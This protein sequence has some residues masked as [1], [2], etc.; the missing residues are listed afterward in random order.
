MLC[1]ESDEQQVNEFT[2]DH[3]RLIKK[4]KE[5]EQQGVNLQR[6]IVESAPK[7]QTETTNSDEYTD[8]FYLTMLQNVSKA[9]QTLTIKTTE[10]QE[11]VNQIK[12][13]YEEKERKADAMENELEDFQIDNAKIY[14]NKENN[15]KFEE[16][17][18]ADEKKR[19]VVE[20]KRLAVIKMKLQTIQMENKIL[21]KEKLVHGL[22]IAGFEQIKAKNKKLDQILNDKKKELDQL[23]KKHSLVI[24]ES[25]ETRNTIN[26]LSEEI[27]KERNI[28]KVSDESIQKKEQLLSHLELQS[29]SYKKSYTISK[30][31]SQKIIEKYETSLLEEKQLNLYLCSLKARCSHL[32]KIKE[33]QDTCHI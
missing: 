11:A 3:D 8:K 12:G 7:L 27:V 14:L 25:K 20:I 9:K 13:R 17:K 31:T 15:K 19:D 16:Q 30:K 21:S 24:E 4:K 33:N 5:H 22:D 26:N 32:N 10:Y 6:K 23:Q 1:N 2:I 29:K 18:R 28:V